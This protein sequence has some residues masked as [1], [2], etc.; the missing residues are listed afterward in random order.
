MGLQQREG[1]GKKSKSKRS[2]AQR[3][4]EAIEGEF[5]ARGI[6]GGSG[7]GAGGVG[8]G[9]GRDEDGDVRMD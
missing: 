1:E 5:R 8:Q 4:L 3:L 9:G 6:V 2:T 7:N